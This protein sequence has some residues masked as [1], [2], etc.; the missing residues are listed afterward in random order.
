MLRQSFPHR[1]KHRN[2]RVAR[3]MAPPQ[4]GQTQFRIADRTLS[5]MEIELSDI[6]FCLSYVG[7]SH[8]CF[9]PSFS[10]MNDLS[11]RQTRNGRHAGWLLWMFRR[12]EGACS[13]SSS[14]IQI[15][16]P[17]KSP[18]CRTDD[19]CPRLDRFTETENPP[20]VTES[21]LSATAY[22]VSLFGSDR[23]VSREE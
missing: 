14:I 9:I 18:G 21:S 4:S 16:T 10:T 7:S 6:F 23:A 1:P 17:P 15:Q 20:R 19:D 12:V 8:A 22:G 11:P 13:L 2:R 5:G 3:S